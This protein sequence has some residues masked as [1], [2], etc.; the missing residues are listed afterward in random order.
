[1][2][3]HLIAWVYVMV[4]NLA[5]LAF[6][7]GTITPGVMATTDFER[8]RNQWLLVTSIAFLSGNFWV[9]ALLCFAICVVARRRD[10]NPLALYVFLL[11]AVPPI[12]RVIPGFG[13]IE[14]LFAIYH[15]RILTVAI[16]L[17]AALAIRAQRVERSAELRLADM[18]ILA[19]LGYQF[20]ATLLQLP[21][22]NYLR[23]LIFLA[24]DTGI[25]YYVASRAPRNGD[26]FREVMGAFVAAMA[27]MALVAV[28]ETAKSWWVYESLSGPFGAGA[29]YY[30]TRGDLGL[31]R[32]KAALGH[33][34]TLGYALG[35]ALMLTHGIWSQ[36][37]PGGRRW[38]LVGLLCA[39][40][41]VTFSRGPWVGT[42]AGVLYLMVSGPGKTRRILLAIVLGTLAA[43]IL[44]MTRFGR[45][46]YA[47][48]PFVG[49]VDSGSITYR[50]QL[51]DTS[52]EVL[53]QNLWF[54]DLG[55]LSNP[56]MEKMRQ[57]EGI[58]DMV[59]TY[60]QVAMPYGL[61]GLALFMVC[62]HRAWRGVRSRSVEGE[63]A[64]HDEVATRHALRAALVT[65]VLTIA[66]VSSVAL[67]PAVYWLII[68]LCIGHGDLVAL[69]VRD[70]PL[71]RPAPVPA[72][73]AAVQ[74]P[75]DPAPPPA[76]A[77]LAPALVA[78]RL[79]P[80]HPIAPDAP[81][82]S[83][84]KTDEGFSEPTPRSP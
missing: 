71:W 81:E 8:R 35:V 30:T 70:T 66:T 53:Q 49:G 84:G 22:S 40:M 27:V 44:A 59:N 20:L 23:Q 18:A 47:M 72:A 64:S 63:F 37:A 78:A 42:A 69:A 51:W 33:P 38:L 39:G 68:G 7:R 2:P 75:A 55:Y 77:P 50:Q 61:V 58:I 80:L 76:P 16:L 29:S 28:F 46:I 9:Y 57:G 62:L 34:I 3:A 41:L 60:L 73:D 48:L 10:A 43:G 14:H 52:M 1:M 25:I 4:V 26:Q 74:A 6:L 24:L 45:S 5:A 83:P 19:F 13:P 79:R 54:G 32:A 15:E 56:L 21:A 36:L 65:V 12:S 17:P 67:V 31:L 11:F 82:P